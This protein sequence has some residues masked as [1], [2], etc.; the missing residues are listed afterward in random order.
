[1][2]VDSQWHGKLDRFSPVKHD[3]SNRTIPT[4]DEVFGLADR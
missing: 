4:S 3:A 1:V 2:T